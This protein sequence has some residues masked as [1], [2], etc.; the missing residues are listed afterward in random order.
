MKGVVTLQ[1]KLSFWSFLHPDLTLRLLIIIGFL[2]LVAI[3]YAFGIYDGFIHNDTTATF[4]SLA[5]LLLYAIPAWGLL[6]LKRWARL[7]ELVLSIIFVVIGFIVMFG[8][9]MTM[10]VITVV[11]HGLIAIYLLSDDCRRAFGLIN[12]AD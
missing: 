10:G 3:G 12:K 5:A 8:Y 6:K 9:N 11:P 2:L 1:D 4:N 7:F